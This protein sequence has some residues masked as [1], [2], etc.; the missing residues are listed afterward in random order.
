MLSLPLIPPQD[1]SS[2]WLRPT[3]R[4]RPDSP[5]LANGQNPQQTHRQRQQREEEKKAYHA[6]SP[7]A[8]LA[9]DEAAIEQRK[10]A[11]RLF[12]SQ[13]IRPPG[14]P[15]TLQA[16]TEEALEREE[17][18][19]LD[20]Q[21]SGMRDMQAQQQLAEAQQA[22][23]ETAAQVDAGGEEER[24]LDD[25]IPD[26]DVTA[27]DVTFN[28]DSIMEGSQLE[29]EEQNVE[30]YVEMEEAELTGAARDEEDLGLDLERDLDDSIAEAGSYQHT[31]T[32]VEDS[33]SES[34]LQ[35]SF[36]SRSAP[37]P[38]RTP[39]DRGQ[40]EPPQLMGSLQERLR[41]QMGAPEMLSRSPGNLDLSSS[42][43]DSSLL[44]SS[45]AMPRGRGRGGRLRRGRHS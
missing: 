11:V 18:A 17:Q 35:D 9:A 40:I 36:A 33:D 8:L 30:Q 16:M 28:E 32:E 43:L 20:R 38:A 1:D 45:P 10:A 44:G 31:D 25:E 26:A 2:T 13:W 4:P 6:R 23:N 5:P 27:A 37:R 19:E 14:I 21:E 7:L 29:H 24:N 3:Y 41:A 12:G 22:A 42:I 39:L 34:E 15:K